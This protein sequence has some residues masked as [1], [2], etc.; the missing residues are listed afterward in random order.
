[1]T[2]RQCPVCLSIGTLSPSHR[3]DSQEG[4]LAVVAPF[5][6]PFRCSACNWRGMMGRLSIVRHRTLNN[7]INSIIFYGV[8]IVA[9]QFYVHLREGM[10]AS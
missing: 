7:V 9:L 2:T 6:H 5:V 10:R 8:V 1:M 4:F 3:R